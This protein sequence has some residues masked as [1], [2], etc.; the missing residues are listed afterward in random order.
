[1]PQFPCSVCDLST[2]KGLKNGCIEEAGEAWRA[3]LGWALAL[4]EGCL[5]QCASGLI[6]SG[7]LQA[8]WEATVHSSR[9]SGGGCA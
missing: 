3:W 9:A 7:L 5:S 8:G 4:K 1:L 6:E 2:E